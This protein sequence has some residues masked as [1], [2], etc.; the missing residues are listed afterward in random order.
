MTFLFTDVEGSTRR[1]ESDADAMR[2]ALAAHDKVL[3]DAIEAHGGF[4][5]KHTGDGV[6]AAFSSPKSAVDAAVAAQRAQELPV[7]M[8][9][10]TGEAELRDGDYFG[11]VLNRAARV[12]AAGH[13]GQILLAES[14]AVLLSGVDLIDLGARRLRDVPLPIGLFQVQ[15]E[16]L[17][18]DFPP[19]RALDTTPGNLRPATTSLIGRESEVAEIRA[20]VKAH[21][22]VTLTGVGGVGKTRLAMEV[23]ARL[24]DEFPDGVWV[25][26]LAAVIDPAAVPDAAA[27]VL[28]VTQQPGKTISESVTAALEGRLRLLV[29]DNCEHLLDS[30]ADLVEAILVHSVT[31]KILTTSREGLGVADEHLW[32]VPSLD[33]NA[34]IGS[35]AVT[36]F[37][38][39]AKAVSPRFSLAAAEDAEAVVEICRRLDGVPLAIELAASR[40]SSMAAREV[41]DRLAQ[42][43]RLLVGSRRG[44]Q[45]HQT[46]RHTVA[47][48]YDLLDDAEKSLLNRCSVF[49]GGFDVQSLCAVA[50]FDHSD[51]YL[52]LDQLDALVRKSL[53]NTDQSTGR[54][55]YSMLETIREFAEEQLAI[56]GAS[57]EVRTA[58]ARYFA[59]READTLAVW[60]S[61]AQRES[62]S[63][64]NHELANL[65]TAFRWAADHE[66]LDTAAAI[67]IHTTLLGIM[68]E[69]YESFAW[70]EEL[71]EPARAVTHPRLAALYLMAS[72][73]WLIGRIKDA[74]RNS[75]AGQV[76][77]A[78][79]RY[80]VPL[81]FESWFASV[82]TA[83]GQ[84]ERALQW[85]REE[86]ARGR[87]IH[88]LARLSLVASLVMA[89]SREDAMDIADGAIAAA[90]ST[91]NPW[92][93]SFALLT[94]GMAYCDANP[95]RARDALRD[96]LVIAQDSGNRY[97]ESHVANV[98]GRLE[99]RHGEPLAAL[100]YLTLA[101]R[102]YHDSGNISVIQIPLGSLA[103][104]FHRLGRRES[105]ATI[106]GFASGPLTKAWIPELI[107]AIAGL[108]N[109]LGASALEALT[110]KGK[111]MT[112]AAM[113]IYAYDQIDQARAELNAIPQ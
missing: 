17:R 19:L 111:T 56:S 52:V 92:A 30:V 51:D 45:R 96:A 23:A 53:L 106:A 48:S 83:T 74:V 44:L 36:L 90:A 40:I 9:L 70:V 81:G 69:N 31:V 78:S 68:V 100:D 77:F 42:R 15:A 22:L 57:D 66:D 58:H 35:A 16:G 76:V 13:G 88:G 2:T 54:T 64:F 72:Q 24:A 12:M 62:Y 14:T 32:P 79:G 94:Y 6:C 104:L 10:A 26:E 101:I 39:R 113:A 105:A 4:L 8:G 29:I 18:T 41:R 21:R 3:R 47:W 103:T 73:S 87:D 109:V 91:H 34:G 60:N 93:R 71:I 112:T 50:G 49:T 85:E 80:E 11:A 37:V 82:Y 89:N 75:E 86:L 108:R 97:I 38:E 55:R 7:R 1:W 99:A 102:N 25:F 98:L 59:R 46:L 95:V 63:W 110:R 84:P 67:A 65:R 61:P 28:G 20:A 33:V 27:A 107:K 5:F 43:F